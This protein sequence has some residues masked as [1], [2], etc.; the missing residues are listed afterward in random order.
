[1]PMRGYNMSTLAKLCVAFLLGLCAAMARAE[2]VQPTLTI[3]AAA[4][5]HHFTAA[6]L[7]SRGDLASIQIPPQVDYNISLTLQAVPLLDLLSAFPLEGFD[8]LEASA[9]DGFLAQIPLALIEAGKSGGSVAW[10]AVENPNHPW[11]KLPGK[12]AGAGPFYLIWQYPE[13]SRVSN[14]QWPYML[15]KLTAV[16]FPE[17]RWPQLKVDA[18]LPADA[19][20]RLGEDV[21]QCL[22][23]HR[24]NGGGGS[25][26]G[27][28]L[29]QP[30]AAID[31]MTEAGLRALV[32]DP[33]SVR[34]WPQQQMPAFPP[35]VLPDTEL[36]ALI[37]YLR[38]IASQ[39]G[40]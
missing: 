40:R 16:Q 5:A 24:L 21:T 1:M 28:D 35:T 15:E 8:R 36:N 33:K 38:Q 26:I 39:R 4:V 25:E 10:I 20:A 7:L 31:Y 14:E 29:G 12:D 2:P 18:S 30:M 19:S 23:C 22:P 13:R 6:E 32:R 3:T 9:T 17:L 37:A 27:P 11:P 34:T